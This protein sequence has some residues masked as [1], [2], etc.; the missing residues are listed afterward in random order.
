MI[1]LKR[2]LPLEFNYILKNSFK[3]LFQKKSNIVIKE[4]NIY[5][6]DSPSYG[7]I[8]DQAIAFSMR[9]FM[10]EYFPEYNQIEFLEDTFI[11]YVKWIKRHIKL[12][13]IICLNGGGNM[14]VL[15]QKYEA[16]RRF[17]I[18]QFPNNKIIIFPQTMDYENSKYGLYE[19]RRSAK[20]YCR[21]NN[22]MIMAREERT[23]NEMKNNYNINQVILCPDIVLYLNYK[24]LNTK[25][26]NE[27][28]IC[29]RNDNEKIID[30][31]AMLQEAKQ[32]GNN[33]STQYKELNGINNSNR[34]K[35]IKEKLLEI[36]SFKRVITDRLHGMIF[37]YITN[38]P[39]IAMPNSNGKV[40]GVYKWIKGKGSTIF[41]EKFD[42]NWIIDVENQSLENEFYI[43]S[44]KI[45]RFI[46]G[47]NLN[48][49]N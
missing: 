44:K 2:V 19:K 29:L 17:I 35:I 1:R 37:A 49:K 8:G 3:I 15:Y 30:E 24:N 13:D 26:E 31:G 45:N 48:G 20:I 27:L 33:I 4:K 34:E 36:S 7:N 11:S 28:G 21:H 22:L 18:K 14:G 40:Q 46:K 5:F 47:D 25:R 10:K 6:L 32:L 38:T 43:L 39:C 42:N 16:I 9:K 12:D 41:K 23:F